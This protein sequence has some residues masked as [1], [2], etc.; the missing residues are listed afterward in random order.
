MQSTDTWYKKY[1]NF[2]YK[3]L[4]DCPEAG[5]DCWNLCMYVY[6][7]YR[8]IDIKQRSWDFCNIVDEDW[9]NKTHDRMYEKGFANF[10]HIFK[11]VDDEPKLFDIILMSIGSTN[12]TN[13]CAMLV[14][15]SRILQTMIKHTSW[16]APYGNYYKQY[17]TGV[18]RWTGLTS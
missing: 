15:N 7:D 3:H 17:T 4:G 16:I 5:I 14:D 11:K 18:Y 9:Y 1:T 8:G 13:H 6:K 10:S 2:P 12:V